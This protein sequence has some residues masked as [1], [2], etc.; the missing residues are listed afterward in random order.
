MY[1]KI[2][3]IKTVK[4][5]DTITLGIQNG[6]YF[7]FMTVLCKV[8]VIFLKEHFC[9]KSVTSQNQ[10][11]PYEINIMTQENKTE[12]LWSEL[13]SNSNI[14]DRIVAILKV[15]KSHLIKYKILAEENTKRLF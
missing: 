13:I 5:N 15:I 1:Y 10:L 4:N 11:T 12:L 9:Y 14:D 7:A 8:E 3:F 2:W 6:G